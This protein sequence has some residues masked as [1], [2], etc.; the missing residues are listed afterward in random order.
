MQ[1]TV[2]RNLNISNYHA[3]ASRMKHSTEYQK[4]AI[5]SVLLTQVRSPKSS[6]KSFECLDHWREVTTQGI[7]EVHLS[8]YPADRG[9]TSVS[10][11]RSV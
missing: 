3:I 9:P 1:Q 5:D 8:I 4:C 10:D 2:R 6:K 11:P 7:T